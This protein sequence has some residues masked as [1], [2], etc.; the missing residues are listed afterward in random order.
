MRSGMTAWRAAVRR[1][2]AVDVDGGGAGAG[3]LRAHLG[4]AG[5]EVDDL[6]LAR[7]VLDD[8][9]ALGQRRRHHG[10]VGGADGDLGERDARAAEAF[11]RLGDDVAGLDVDLGAERLQRLDEEID[12]P[13]ADGAAAGERHLRLAHARQQRADHPE[14]RAHARDELVGRGGVDDVAGPQLDRFALH[15]VLAGALAEHHAIDAVV[16]EDALQHGDVGKARDVVEGQRL[17]R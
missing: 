4:E 1:L 8:G 2:D 6:R 13:R 7:G 12:R 5:G 11:R 17:R 9:L 3:N 10:D 15:A 14:A 16:A